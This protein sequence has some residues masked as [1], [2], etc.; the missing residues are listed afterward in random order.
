[1]R[2]FREALAQSLCL[3]GVGSGSGTMSPPGARAPPGSRPIV[4]TVYGQIKMDSLAIVFPQF[5]H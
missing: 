3:I 5:S 4:L 2:E 1:M